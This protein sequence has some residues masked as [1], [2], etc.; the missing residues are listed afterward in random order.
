MTL[1][2]PLVIGEYAQQLSEEQARF[3]NFSLDN[4]PLK[5][6]FAPILDMIAS[7][8]EFSY[9][10]P[11]KIDFCSTTLPVGQRIFGAVQYDDLV[12]KLLHLNSNRSF[13]IIVDSS[14]A[15]SL[16]I[17]LVASSLI[18]DVPGLLFSST[19]KGIFS[20]IIARLIIELSKGIGNQMPS[21]K[22]LGIFHSHEEAIKEY[23]LKD[24]VAH[25]FTLNFLA[26]CYPITLFSL[27]QIYE[28]ASTHPF[29]FKTMLSRLGHLTK[30]L[31]FI[32]HRLS[33]NYRAL[34]GLSPGDLIM[35][36]ESSLSCVNQKLE[37]SM[38]AA[39]GDFQVLGILGHRDAHYYFHYQ[40]PEAKETS[41]MKALEIISD[42]SE[43][44]LDNNNNDRLRELTEQWRVPMSIEISRLPMS[45]REISDLRPGQ[46]ID[47][48]RK[49][50]DPLEIVIENKVIGFCAP[51]QIDGR[52]GIKVL[53]I[54]GGDKE[55]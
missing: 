27:Q 51:V 40:Q 52:L 19:E 20:F 48:H 2:V 14:L 22:I 17:R 10:S 47:L 38:S 29:N 53:S 46:V 41:S 13:F 18:E 55:S 11:A 32:V 45:L 6:L 33:I 37:G 8:I 44:S 50:G 31:S 34:Q 30:D 35:F 25:H 21:L 54:E 5:D 12:I 49:I 15:R 24:Y 39:W 36:D 43:L 28:N 7:N 42:E 1:V 23:S 26:T 16:L 3:I 9:K 4:E